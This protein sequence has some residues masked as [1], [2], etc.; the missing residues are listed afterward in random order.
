MLAHDIR[1]DV[2]RA[3]D[4]VWSTGVTNPIVVSDLLGT[5]L[6]AGAAKQ[7][8]VWS[9]LRAAAS[10][11]AGR[12]IASELAQVRRKYGI[13]SGS[14]IEAPEF[15]GTDHSLIRSMDLLGPLIKAHGDILG[16]IYEHILA[17]LSLAGHFGQF[18]T[19]RHIVDFMVELIDPQDGEIVADPACGSGGFLV[20][21][22]DYRNRA[23]RSGVEIGVEIDR[24][25]SRI[26][27]ANTV[28]HGMNHSKILQGDGL[29]R[30]LPDNPHVVLA[31]PPFS[32]VV[33]DDVAQLFRAGSS[34]TELLFVEAIAESLTLNGRAAV[35]VPS[36]VVT[37]GNSA[38]RFVRRL[39]LE[40]NTLEAVIELPSGVFR[41]YT[42]VKTAILIWHNTMPEIA[43]EVKMI[44][45][46]ADGFSRDSRRTPIADNDLPSVLRVLRGEQADIAAVGVEASVIAATGYNLNPSRYIKVKGESTLSDDMTINE[47]LVLLSDS[48]RV[49]A[50]KLAKIEELIS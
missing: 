48:M 4:S 45:V 44:R 3:W 39:L 5:L 28:F 22:S 37:G 46:E 47:S 19:P 31:N 2:D 14:E 42:D 18:R 32:G 13:D 30:E 12:E 26:A 25:I 40:E 35:V 23:G 7:G 6:M 36:G 43:A 1:Q 8:E 9:R 10:R 11:S 27:V 49:I 21:A 16:D 24:T 29:T 38:A 41:P 33:N 34:K 20:S 15:W 17:K 50:A